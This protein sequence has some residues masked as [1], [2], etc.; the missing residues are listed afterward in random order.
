[1]DSVLVV[2]P[3]RR[4]PQKRQ[5]PGSGGQSPPGNQAAWLSDP[6]AEFR[7]SAGSGAEAD[8][9]RAIQAL[10]QDDLAAAQARASGRMELKVTI[11]E[12]N[13]VVVTHRAERLH[14]GDRV[15]VV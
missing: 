14:A 6:A 8:G 2:F 7:G 15:Q 5:T 1:M 11:V 12:A 3:P 10:L 4:R 13:G 9:K